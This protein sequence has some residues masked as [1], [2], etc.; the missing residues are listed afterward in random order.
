[1]DLTTQ[2]GVKRAVCFD[3]R[4][5]PLFNEQNN[6]QTH[7][8]LIKRPCN[9]SHK[10]FRPTQFLEKFPEILEWSTLQK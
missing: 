5:Y 1:M 4:R 2:T 8:V 6:F 3:E 7:A 10:L 9:I